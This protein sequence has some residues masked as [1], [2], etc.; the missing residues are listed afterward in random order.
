[1]KPS[2]DIPK[3]EI[4]KNKDSQTYKEI[5]HDTGLAESTIRRHAQKMIRLGKWKQTW[6]KED[7]KIVMAF[8]RIK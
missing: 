3:K 2:E 5:A 6:K 8:E 7:G 4:S 1:M